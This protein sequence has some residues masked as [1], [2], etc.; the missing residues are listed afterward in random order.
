MTTRRRKSGKT[1]SKHTALWIIL[2][3]ALFLIIVFL[4]FTY[5]FKYHFFFHST[6]NRLSVSGMTLNEAKDRLK[7]EAA[8]YLLTIYDRNGEKYHITAEDIDYAYVPGEEEQ[9]LLTSQKPYQWINSLFKE[10]DYT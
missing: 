8:S 7:E 6:I 1:A 4:G 5:Y 3:I 10:Q 2:A 9:K